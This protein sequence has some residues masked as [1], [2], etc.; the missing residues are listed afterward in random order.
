MSVI[1]DILADRKKTHG[2][3][4]KVAEVAQALKEVAIEVEADNSLTALDYTQ[5]EAL[6]MIFSKIARILCGDPSNPDHWL[7]IAGYSTLVF[8][9]IM[10][11]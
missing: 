6:D 5:R 4:Y 10:E 7:D 2:E 11:G 3:F 1:D 9:E 8:K